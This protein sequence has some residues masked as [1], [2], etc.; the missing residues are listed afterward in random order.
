MFVQGWVVD[1]VRVD[2]VV[3]D[4]LGDVIGGNCF[5]QIDY[6]GFGGV[7]DEMVGYVDY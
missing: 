5:G 2:G 3:V 1:C 6:C 7:I 4:V